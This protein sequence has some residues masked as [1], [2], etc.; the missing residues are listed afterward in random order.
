MEQAR[1]IGQGMFGETKIKWRNQSQCNRNL[2]NHGI[3]EKTIQVQTGHKSMND[4]RVY[5][6][7]GLEQQRE[8]YEALLM[9]P[10]RQSKRSLPLSLPF[11]LLLILVHFLQV[12]LSMAVQ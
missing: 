5:K 1:S 12:S 6:R 4:L 2:H 11:C 10:T 7:Y 9:L 3:P 8:A